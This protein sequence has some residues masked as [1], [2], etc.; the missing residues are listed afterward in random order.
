ML[1]A[2]PREVILS[3]PL[4]EA[5]SSLAHYENIFTA[6]E[7]AETTMTTP[8]PDADRNLSLMTV[9]TDMKQLQPHNATLQVEFCKIG[10]V[11]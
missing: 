7:F 10:I 2:V 5:L 1:E 9:M 6:N 4:S 8:A 3:L 11:T